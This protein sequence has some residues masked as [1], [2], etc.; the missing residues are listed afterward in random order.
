M[1]N[2]IIE[3]TNDGYSAIVPSIPMISASGISFA[4][5]VENI[6][7]QIELY[8]CA[9]QMKG[10]EIDRNYEVEFRPSFPG[11]S[12]PDIKQF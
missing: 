5:A 12:Y 7:T 11:N 4:E 3:K 9:M 1:Q 6:T 2:I 10:I 8:I